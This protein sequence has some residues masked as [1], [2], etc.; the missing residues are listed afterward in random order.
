M[1]TIGRGAGIGVLFVIVA[2]FM[3]FMPGLGRVAE[4]LLEPG[5]AL[6]EAY[7]GGVH[8]PLQLLLVAAL[9]CVFYAALFAAIVWRWRKRP[10]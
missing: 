3:L 10:S 9:N 6:P 4:V 5:Y 7:W 1:G 2:F 8:D